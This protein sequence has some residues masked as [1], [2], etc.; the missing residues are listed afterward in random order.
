MVEMEKVQMGA[1]VEQAAVAA[2]QP[3]VLRH[4]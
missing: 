2:Q 4:L 3:V 1:T